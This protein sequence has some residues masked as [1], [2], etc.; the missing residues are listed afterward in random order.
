[1]D[2]AG[3]ILF[4]HRGRVHSLE[5]LLHLKTV[6]RSSGHIVQPETLFPRELV[7]SVGG[8]NANLH[9]GMDYEL[10]GRIFLVG[11]RFQYTEIPF[12]MFR[13]HAEQKTNDGLRTTQALVD[14]ASKLVTLAD[15]FSDETKKE[16]LTEWEVCQKDAWMR[17]GRLARSGLPPPVVTRLRKLKDKVQLKTVKTLFREK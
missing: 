5:D 2:E 13:K 9:D 1:M 11:A 12:G 14:I 4:T 17:S 16:I 3:K 6:W 15:R 7:L 10:W 8:L